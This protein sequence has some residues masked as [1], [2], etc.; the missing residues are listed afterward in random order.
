MEDKNNIDF[1]ITEVKKYRVGMRCEKCGEELVATGGTSYNGTSILYEHK[2]EG[3]GEIKNLQS[4]FPFIR[5]INAPV[6]E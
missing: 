3:C 5:E 1:I 4:L 6:K 2:C